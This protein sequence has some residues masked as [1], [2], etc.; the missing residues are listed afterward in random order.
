MSF[1]STEEGC[2][3]LLRSLVYFRTKGSKPNVSSQIPASI[4]NKPLSVA[5]WQ[6][7]AAVNLLEIHI[8]MSWI[9]G[10]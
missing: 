4:A 3:L 1:I 9:R 7:P 5:R 2:L 10:L 6:P 8:R